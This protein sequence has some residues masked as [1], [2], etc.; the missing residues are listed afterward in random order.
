MKTFVIAE[1]GAN[2]NRSWSTARR[3]IHAASAAGATAVKFQNYTSSKMYVKSTPDFGVYK[4]I[5]KLISDIELPVNWMSDLKMM[6]DDCGLEFMSTPFD[7]DAVALLY[8][9]GVKRL[10]IAAFEAS[11]RRLVRCVAETGLPIVFSAGIKMSLQKAQETVDYI[12]DINPN[13]DVTVLHCNSSYPTPFNDINLGQMALLMRNL[14]G[15]HVG[16]SDHT[17]G[18]LIPPVAVALGAQVIEKHYTLDRSLLGPDHPFAIEPSELY[19]MCRNIVRVE[20]SLGVKSDVLTESERQ[21]QMSFA[22]RSLV[23]SRRI[24]PGEL[25]TH[26]NVTTKRPFIEGNIPASDHDSIVG[27]FCASVEIQED[28]MIRSEFVERKL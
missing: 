18:I 28:E 8:K 17:L 9:L 3:L 13:A 19:E 11:D 7:E 1:V 24:R 20:Q 10:K 12:L 14:R 15:V 2:H 16:L 25:L 23:A 26:E 5:P 22:T 27:S 21:G 4:N 6:C